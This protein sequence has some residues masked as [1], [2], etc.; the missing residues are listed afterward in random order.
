MLQVIFPSAL[1]GAARCVNKL[2]LAIGLVIEPLSDVYISSAL[3]HAA[4]ATHKVIFKLA[5]IAGAIRPC[6]YSESVPH[7]FIILHPPL[8][9]VFFSLIS[10]TEFL[11]FHNEESP[12]NRVVYFLF[13]L[14][15]GKQGS[16]HHNRSHSYFLD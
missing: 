4:E 12:G 3:H 5:H 15:W 11:I 9:L 8:P 14:G 2:A 7:Q 16:V 13:D 10:P 6:Q 1:I